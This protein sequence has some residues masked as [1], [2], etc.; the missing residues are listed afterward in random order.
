MFRHAT[1]A[2]LIHDLQR[3]PPEAEVVEVYHDLF[4]QTRNSYDGNHLFFV[5]SFD[6]ELP[7]WNKPDDP[8]HT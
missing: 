4:V 8:L 2:Q 6:R 5:N 1:V 7:D 3:F